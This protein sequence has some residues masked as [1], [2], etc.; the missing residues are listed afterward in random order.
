M[1]LYSSTVWLRYGLG[2]TWIDLGDRWPATL[3]PLSALHARPHSFIHSFR[4]QCSRTAPPAPPAPALPAPPAPPTPPVLGSRSLPP[5]RPLIGPFSGCRRVS[6]GQPPA[7][8]P[9]S[10]RVTRPGRWWQWS[11]VR[12][13]FAHLH[14]RCAALGG[15]HRRRFLIGQGGGKRQRRALVRWY[16]ERRAREGERERKWEEYNPGHSRSSNWDKC[17][18]H[19]VLRREASPRTTTYMPLPTEMDNAAVSAPSSWSS[20][21]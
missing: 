16:C 6:M 7:R 19:W 11:V 3:D 14:C 12:R 21:A 17:G 2:W 20:A 8:W 15:G 5:S 10:S 1:K 18:E 13:P 4:A 9:M